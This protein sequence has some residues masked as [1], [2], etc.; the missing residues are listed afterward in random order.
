MAVMLYI[1]REVF[2]VFQK[3]R[4][5]TQTKR[6]QIGQS[7]TQTKREQ[8]GQSGSLLCLFFK[9]SPGQRLCKLLLFFSFI[10]CLSILRCRVHFTFWSFPL[11]STTRII[12]TKHCGHAVCHVLYQNSS[13]Y[14]DPAAMGNSWFWLTE[15]LKVFSSETTISPWG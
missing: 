2:P 9:N 5:V 3:W 15:T 12:G 8:I 10:V 7:V 4:Y 6:E 13:I 11:N 1:L 14:P